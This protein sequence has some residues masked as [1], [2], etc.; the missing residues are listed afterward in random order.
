VGVTLASGM[1][2][3]LLTE[4]TGLD[5]FTFAFTGAERSTAWLLRA[6]TVFDFRVGF[7]AMSIL[8]QIEISRKGNHSTSFFSLGSRLS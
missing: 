4:P 6:A 1:A 2:M 3:R 7:F 5:F 8:T